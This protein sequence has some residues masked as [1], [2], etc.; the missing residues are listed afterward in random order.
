LIRQ[1][2]LLSTNLINITYDNKSYFSVNEFLL[3]NGFQVH[4]KAKGWNGDYNY[5]Y[6]EDHASIEGH[7]LVANMVIENIKQIENP[8]LI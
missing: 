1:S 5:N 4:N 6:Q 7:Q 2:L 8:S 3:D